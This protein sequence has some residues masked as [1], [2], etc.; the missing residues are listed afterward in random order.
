LTI[1]WCQINKS[2]FENL[3]VGDVVYDKS[4]K[5]FVVAEVYDLVVNHLLIVE[6]GLMK[7]ELTDSKEIKSNKIAIKN[8]N[9][10]ELTRLKTYN[11]WAK[12]LNDSSIT[13]IVQLTSNI[14]GFNFHTW[15][16]N[17]NL[18]DFSPDHLDKKSS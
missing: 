6:P 12:I 2:E 3:I 1:R 14:N 9:E 8:A 11:N 16:G 4:K 13:R 10:K 7:V 15:A 18:W 17:W 5:P